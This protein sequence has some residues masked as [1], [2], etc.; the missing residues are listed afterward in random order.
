VWLRRG[1]M[2]LDLLKDV[3]MVLQSLLACE[4]RGAPHGSVHAT[5]MISWSCDTGK[6]GIWSCTRDTG[7]Q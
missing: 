7:G 2:G 5:L 1:P 6:A 3:P 4:V